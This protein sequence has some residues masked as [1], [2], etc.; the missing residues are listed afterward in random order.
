[1]ADKTQGQTVI[2]AL[3]IPLSSASAPPRPTQPPTGGGQPPRPDNTLPQQPGQPNRPDN[4]LPP[5]A[6]PRQGQG[7]AMLNPPPQPQQP[8]PHKG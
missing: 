2:T 8:T 7:G 1:M 6:Q 3:I 5:T 4:T